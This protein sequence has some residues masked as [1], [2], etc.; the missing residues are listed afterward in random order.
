MK[1]GAVFLFL[2]LLILFGL[3]QIPEASNE[4]NWTIDQKIMTTV[5][6]VDD[7]VQLRN[8]R[9][10][11]YQSETEYERNY[12]DKTLK[13]DDIVSVD[14]ILSHFS[15]WKG[16]AHAFLSFGFQGKEYIEYVAVSVEIRKEEGEEYSPFFGL[17]KQYELNYVV[18][19]ERDVIRL[20]T[21]FRE[22][23]LYI[24]PIQ[25]SKEDIAALFL[26]M[27]KRILRLE[28]Q[29]EFYN[30]LASSCM[31][32]IANHVNEIAPETIPWSY[33][34]VF[35]GYADEIAYELDLVNTSVSLDELRSQYLVNTMAKQYGDGERF[36]QIIRK[37]I[38]EN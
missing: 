29:P 13:V 37:G 26:S 25:A 18:A 11:T 3:Y 19:D 35:P 1:R 27:M 34:T 30:T 24:F 15:D 31:T 22:E 2:F 16:A 10:F 21:N 38:R 28:T 7:E 20:R 12:Y 32:N 8:I 17:F 6:M 5:R 14:F 36:S 33:K 23:P 4:R 9:N